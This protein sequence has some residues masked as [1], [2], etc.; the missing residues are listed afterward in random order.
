[1]Y[2]L[3]FICPAL[4]PV[5]YLLMT[6]IILKCYSTFIS[7]VIH[8]LMQSNASCSREISAPFSKPILDVQKVCKDQTTECKVAAEPITCWDYYIT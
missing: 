8:R 3:L 5:F 7:A 4:L 1:M 6:D 2:S